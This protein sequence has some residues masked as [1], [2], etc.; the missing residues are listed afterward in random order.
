MTT[1]GGNKALHEVYTW[2]I[3]KDSQTI[4]WEFQN[5]NKCPDITIQVIHP[6]AIVTVSISNKG[7][8][9]ATGVYLK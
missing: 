5:G 9:V 6:I 8:S 1:V 3:T 4:N 2:I 7:I